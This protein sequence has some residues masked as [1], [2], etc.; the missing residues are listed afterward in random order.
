M[1]KKTF[2][3]HS[4]PFNRTDTFL[5]T[6]LSRDS[7]TALCGVNSQAAGWSGFTPRV[8]YISDTV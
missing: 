8:A 7:D 2:K 6:S 4:H 3:C 1:K 5:Y